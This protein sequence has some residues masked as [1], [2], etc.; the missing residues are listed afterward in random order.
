MNYYGDKISPNMQVTPEGYLV[1]KNVPIGRIGWMD[2]LG[3]E[4]PATFEE[5]TGKKVRVYRSPEELFSQATIASFEGKPVTNTHP[6]ANLDI[7]TAPATERGHIQNVRRD[8]DFLVADLYVIDAG[9]ISEIQNALKRE[10]SCG[11]DCSWHKIDGGYEQRDIVGNHVAV[12]PNGRAGPRV[13]IKDA[14]PEPND[15]KPVKGGRTMS[16]FTE[17]VATALGFKQWVQDA[18]PEEIAE[19]LESM[20]E[21]KDCY[22]KKT[23]DAEP[24]PKPEEKPVKDEEMPAWFKTYKEDQDKAAKDHAAKDEESAAALKDL[25]AKFEALKSSNA[26]EEKA[27]TADAVLDAMEEELKE[28]AKD[29][30]TE[31]EKKEREAKEAAD[32]AAKDKKA[33]DALTAPDPEGPKKG[34][35]DALIRQL[36]HD[37]RP[38][39][40]ANP[41]EATRLEAAKKFR[42]TVQDIRGRAAL[43]GYADILGAVNSN[44]MAA[45]DQATVNRATAEERAE[46]AAKAWNA[47]GDKMVSQP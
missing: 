36:A 33:K 15:V 12:V 29:G 32:K 20:K 22:D 3:Q 1:A 26:K 41:D 2:Y 8:G 43:N 10:V 28:P 7:N 6:T 11:Y 38:I 31:E 40:L 21:S 13:A 34:A 37:M 35:A 42:Q 18:A 30:E 16:K 19:A 44:K 17:K 47:A 5:P 14:K 46:T 24:E 39:I 25:A 9:L 27:E 45:M 4:I 23:K